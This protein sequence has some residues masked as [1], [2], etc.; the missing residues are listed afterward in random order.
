M[1]GMVGQKYN[2]GS[3]MPI[4]IPYG[5]CPTPADTQAKLATVKGVTVLEDG[6]SIRVKFT[7]AQSY[8]G[9]P[10]LNVNSLGA[11]AIKL[12]T[13]T[14]AGK[15]AWTAGAVVDF[16]YDGTNWIQTSGGMAG[17]TNALKSIGLNIEDGILVIDPVT[18]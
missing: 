8:D 18:E 4:K 17:I 6:L 5:V 16:Y 11:K 1:A 3:V 13:A 7:Y 2:N 10:S 9:V 12:D 15:D 14:S